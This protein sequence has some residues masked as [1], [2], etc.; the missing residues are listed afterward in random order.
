M[1]VATSSKV[2]TYSKAY[3]DQS[4]KE[5]LRVISS[6]PQWKIASM[7]DSDDDFLQESNEESLVANNK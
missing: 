6:W 1:K 3:V 5:A 2:C 7:L 4:L